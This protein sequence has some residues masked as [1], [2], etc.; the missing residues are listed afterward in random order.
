MSQSGPGTRSHYLYS[1]H[2]NT[3]LERSKLGIICFSLAISLPPI[4]QPRATREKFSETYQTKFTFKRK[5]IQRRAQLR[6]LQFFFLLLYLT[7]YKESRNNNVCLAICVSIIYQLA[8]G[9][10]R[11]YE[12]CTISENIVR[13]EKLLKLLSVFFV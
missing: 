3:C 9:R 13:E 2:T 12:E 10:D 8:S 11:P 4:R 7:H 5:K 1:Q 6:P